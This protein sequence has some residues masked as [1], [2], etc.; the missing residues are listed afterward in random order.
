[1]EIGSDAHESSI[2]GIMANISAG[3][4]S[5]IVFHK[6]PENS[7]IDCGLKFVGVEKHVTGTVVRQEERLNETYV[8]GVKFDEV[9][10]ELTDVIDNMAEDFDICEIRYLMKGDKACFPDCSFHPLC[11]KRIKKDF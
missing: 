10:E 1:M 2:P 6:L 9:I 11:A 8:A 4:M 3:G 5:L 7:K